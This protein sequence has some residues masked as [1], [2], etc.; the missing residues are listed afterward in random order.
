MFNWA[1]YIKSNASFVSSFGNGL[2]GFF[3]AYSSE[4]GIAPLRMR[5]HPTGVISPVLRLID[6]PIKNEKI[7]LS[8]SNRPLQMFVYTVFVIVSMRLFSLCCWS[9]LD[10]LASM[11]LL[12]SAFTNC[13]EFW[14]MSL[15]LA[16]S[17]ITKYRM[18]PLT[19][20]SL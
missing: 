8:R 2:G 10:L 12:K 7:N 15:I 5:L 6:V 11:A 19:A 9:S 20:T 17:A 14:Y 4:K 13:K 18:L 16:M 1:L 3:D